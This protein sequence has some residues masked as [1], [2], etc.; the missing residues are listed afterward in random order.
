MEI[1]KEELKL[2]ND[3]LKICLENEFSVKFPSQFSMNH[4]SGW[5]NHDPKQFVVCF[6]KGKDFN[7]ESTWGV[8]LHESCHIDQIL[9]KSPLWFNDD[10]DTE[11]DYIDELCIRKNIKKSKK[12]ERYFKGMLELEIDC[13]IRSLEKLKKYNLNINKKE[14]IKRG[15]VY[16]KSYYSFYTL[17]TWYD[18]KYR[19]YDQHDIIDRM[20][21]FFDKNV[22][23][24]WK[25]CKCIHEFLK[26]TGL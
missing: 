12:V 4:T 17:K 21:D 11:I 20:P 3:T 23:K 8:F 14:Y 13:E 26:E 6:P 9:D 25:E 16:L 7:Y 5:V 10:I 1:Q 24:Y 18:R 19:I 22:D 15:N 2:L